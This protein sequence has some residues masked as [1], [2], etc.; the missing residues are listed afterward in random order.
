V[1]KIYEGLIE[2]IQENKIG[3]TAD[4][5]AWIKMGIDAAKEVIKSLLTPNEIRSLFGLPAIPS[6]EAQGDKPAGGCGF[7]D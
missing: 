5:F 2:W 1:T 7:V 6:P 4:D 3:Y